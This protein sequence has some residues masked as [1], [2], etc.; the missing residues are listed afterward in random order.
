MQNS[1]IHIDCDPVATTIC[2]VEAIAPLA[3]VRFLIVEDEIVQ[4]LL[5]SEMLTDV[6]GPRMR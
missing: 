3:G 4:A 1:S 2:E 5:L 6:G